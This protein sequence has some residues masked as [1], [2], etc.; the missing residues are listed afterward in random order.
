MF[1]LDRSP[2]YWWPVSVMFAAADG[3]KFETETF[4]ASFVR[5]DNDGFKALMDEVREKK[6][7]DAELVPRIVNDWRNVADATGQLVPFSAAALARLCKLPGVPGAI[8]RAF[9]DSHVKAGEGN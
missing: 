8:V 3:G 1:K 5:L 2:A 9:L 6:L 4:E 7:P